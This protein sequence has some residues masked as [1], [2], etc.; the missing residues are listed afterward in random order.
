MSVQQNQPLDEIIEI[1][2]NDTDPNKPKRIQRA[3]GSFYAKFIKYN[4][5]LIREGKT[6]FYVDDTKFYDPLEKVFKNKADFPNAPLTSSVLP[7]VLMSNTD[8]TYKNL[9]SN[10]LKTLDNPNDKVSIK[11]DLKKINFKTLISLIKKTVPNVK[12]ISSSANSN[13]KIALSDNN[14]YDLQKFNELTYQE[15]GSDMEFIMGLLQNNGIITIENIFYDPDFLSDTDSETSD[16]ENHGNFFKFYNETHFD[17][18]RYD[19]R[20]KGFCDYKKN[21]LLIALENG[22]LDKEKCDRFKSITKNGSFPTCKLTPLCNE[23]KICIDVRKL[24]PN[25]KTANQN[26]MFYGK[27]EYQKF[28]IGLIE[29]HYFIIEKT[30]NT[31]FSLEHYKKIKHIN[32]CNKISRIKKGKYD[33]S[34]DNYINS[35]DLVKILI[36]RKEELLSIVP[37]DDI[38]RTPYFDTIMATDD[39]VEVSDMDW[40]INELIKTNNDDAYTVYFDFETITGGQHIPYMVCCITQDGQRKRYDGRNC[41]QYFINWLTKLGKEKIILVAHNLKYDFSFI[42]EYIFR[43]N[44]IISGSRLLGGGGVIYGSNKK[45]VELVFLDSYN[46]ISVPLF[47]FADMFNLTS[48]KEFIPYSAYTEGILDDEYMELDTVYKSIEFKTEEQKEL[49]DSNCKKWGCIEGSKVNMIEYSKRYC[50]IDCEVLKQ[51]FEIFRTQIEEVCGLDIH[52]YC[53]SASVANDYMIK[54]GVYNNCY[55]ISGIPQAFIQKC[56]VGGKVMTRRNEKFI[57]EKDT[58]DYDMT[59]MYPSAMAAMDGI[60]MGTPKLITED[61][62]NDEYLNSIDGYFIKVFCINNSEKI[63][64][65]PM[66][67]IVNDEGIRQY[68][69]DTKGKTF[70]LDKTMYEDAK[71]FLGLKFNILCGYYY[72]EGRNPQIK[73]TIK[74]LFNQRLKMK[75]EGNPIQSVYKLIMNSAYGKS[76]L[77]PIALDSVVIDNKKY[78]KFIS[79]NYNFVKEIIPLNSKVTQVKLIKPIHEHFNNCYFGVEVLSQA[80]RLMSRVMITAE[81]LKIPMYYT[82]TDSIHIDYEGVAVLESEY[83]RKYNKELNGKNLGQFHIDFELDDALDHTIRSKKSVYLGKK[84][85]YDLLEGQDE[86]G[87]T[88]TGDHIRM[89][90]VPNKCIKYY[91]NKL[92][93]GDMLALYKGL[94]DGRA[95]TFDLLCEGTAIKFSYEGFN[96]KSLGYYTEDTQ[97]NKVKCD[98]NVNASS[99]F[100]RRIKF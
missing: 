89:K 84:C 30:Q 16:D 25:D 72:D 99:E 36:E 56:V 77:K 2:Q 53:T 90:G 69:N 8:E 17:F 44:P 86:D 29:N 45:K 26:Q 15:N 71:S 74:H 57:I 60:L 35:F 12:L 50:F 1:L 32:E 47:K 100:A 34:N 73:E 37:F 67:S 98:Y 80:K 54:S 97:G 70:Y 65:F 92:Y 79:K 38:I 91:A 58:A 7:T 64:D 23:L 93:D 31:R 61:K 63:L 5:K 21:C 96:V 41:G 22:G 68:T 6:L 49:F 43:L 75:K 28:K 62:R 82:D 85:Y 88:I 4:E 10:M 11:I 14:L 59:S 24:T 87:N 51:G 48:H 94:H 20:K 33:K 27:K 46:H 39:L 18:S 40:E 83:K 19:I 78:E 13:K 55:K 9:V 76:L 66:L 3:D 95:I 52:N 42:W 81:D